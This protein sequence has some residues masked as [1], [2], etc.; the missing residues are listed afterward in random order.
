MRKMSWCVLLSTACLGVSV[1]S[2][3]CQTAPLTLEG[4]AEPPEMLGPVAKVLTIS[5]TDKA[6]A[7]AFVNLLKDMK[8]NESDIP[9]LDKFIREYP[10]NDIA[11]FWRANIEACVSKPP[12]LVQA[13]AI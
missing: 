12:S 1:G 5:D 4:V 9:K 2:G 13:R 3:I 7:E 6:Y 10:A 11:Y 8:M